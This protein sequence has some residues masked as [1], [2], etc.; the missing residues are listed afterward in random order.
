MPNSWRT[1]PRVPVG[2]RRTRLRYI[3]AGLLLLACGGVLSKPQGGGES[4]FL[5]RCVEQCRGGLEC[6]SDIC[7]RRCLVGESSCADLSSAAVCTDRSIEPGAVAVCDVGCE[8]AS[9][10]AGL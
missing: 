5:Y 2:G 10:C 6:I 7:T 1:N 9:D 3:W 4:H 8:S